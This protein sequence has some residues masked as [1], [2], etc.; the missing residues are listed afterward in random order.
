MLVA[1]IAV[2]VAGCGGAA[3]AQSRLQPRPTSTPTDL[4]GSS[5]L[6]VRGGAATLRIDAATRRYL[7]LADIEVAA[8]GAADESDDEV[9]FPVTGGKLSSPVGVG[10]VDLGGG[11]RV[12][13]NGR[14]VDATRM[15]IRLRERVV[16]AQVRGRRVPLLK[17]V[18]A[19][20]ASAP[21]P[22]ERVV[23]SSRASVVGESVVSALGHALDVEP[24]TRGLPFGTLTIA[25]ETVRRG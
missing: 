15:I 21:A 3:P 6:S 24:L 12:T 13:A 8:I 18:V 11:L 19:P 5:W 17:L 9:R 4:T 2:A 14:H 10:R 16:T 23:V 7:R 22:G 20:P 25:A 1:I